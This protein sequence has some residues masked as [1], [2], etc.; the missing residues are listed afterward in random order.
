MRSRSLKVGD[1]VVFTKSKRSV[2]PG[3]R[4]RQVSPDQKGNL[5]SYVVDK[6]WTIK[7]VHSDGTVTLI[8]RRGKEHTLAQDTPG[9]RRARLWEKL[10]LKN[11]FP[12]AEPASSR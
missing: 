6:Y 9:L 7:E 4:A 5:Y 3:P 1:Q 2:S 11:R 8:T 12:V 10:L